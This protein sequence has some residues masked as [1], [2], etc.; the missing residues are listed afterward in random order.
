[1]ACSPAY[2]ISASFSLTLQCLGVSTGM[3]FKF[4][5]ICEVVNN[6]EGN[7]SYFWLKQRLYLAGYTAKIVAQGELNLVD[8]IARL[9]LKFR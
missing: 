1:M 6:F 4:R 3:P 8:A 7:L 5:E 9:M 2:S